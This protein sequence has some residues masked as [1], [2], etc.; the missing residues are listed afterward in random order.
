MRQPQAAL[1]YPLP[2]PDLRALKAVGRAVGA[3]WAATAAL[4]VFLIIGLA[5]LDDYGVVVDESTQRFLAMQ[6]LAHLRGDAVSFA[7]GNAFY[8]VA[9]E[10]PLLLTENAL[11]IERL[12]GIHLSRHLLT[13]LF[14][15]AGGL[16]AYILAYRLFA[17]RAIAVFAMLL[18]VLHPRLYA[19][20]FFN[21]KDVPFMAMFMISL[22]ATHHAFKKN[23][24][25][26]F[27]LAGTVIGALVNLRILGVVL[28][29]AILAMQGLDFLFGQGRAERK[30]ALLTAAAFALSSAVTT[31][32]LLPILWSDVVGRAAA[33]WSTSSGHPYLPYEIFRG[34][35]YRSNEIPDEY[36]SVWFA[37]TAP[38]FALALGLA[39]AGIVL[40]KG[41]RAPLSALR[42]GMP[43][44]GLLLVGCCAAPASAV[45]LLDVNMYNGWRQMYF[46]WAPFSLL[47]AF[48]LAW[49]VPALASSRRR[50]AA[51]GAI[52]AG[53]TATLIA[54]ALIH[55]NQQVFFNFFV[56]RTTPEYLRTQYM[57]DYWGHPTREAWE[58]LLDA[59]PSSLAEA[60]PTTG[61]ARELLQANR[62][63]LPQALKE[64]T[65]MS[66]TESAS[67]LAYFDMPRSIALRA[68][69]TLPVTHRL[70]VYD[71]TIW[72]LVEKPNVIE[73]YREIAHSDPSDQ[74]VFHVSVEGG[75]LNYSLVRFGYQIHVRNGSVIYAKEPC[76]EEEQL[77]TGF[78]LKLVPRNIND[79]PE[80]RRSGGGE[81]LF[82]YFSGYGAVDGDKCVM[83]IPLPEYPI[84][85]F[86]LRQDIPGVGPIW[87]AEVNPRTSKSAREGAAGE[88]LDA[89]F[90]IQLTDDALVYAKEPCEQADTEP[91]FLL[92][93]I[94]ERV[95]DLPPERRPHGFDNLDFGFAPSGSFLNGGCAASAALPDY[96]IT[97]VAAAQFTGEKTLWVAR[98]EFTDLRAP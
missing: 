6:N 40:A 64:R 91:R 58:R 18:F 70:R 61:F 34:V 39:G 85:G 81:W 32:A 31:Y 12:R 35:V 67:A 29:A 24:L 52:G 83:F 16:A 17:N 38:P 59:R 22:L 90:D 86:S 36:L 33:W 80:H 2:L 7:A 78:S 84:D 63:I 97:G 60:N 47:G 98:F 4:A 69:E 71:N 54:M 28:I 89:L 11:G 49:L 92:H 21:S 87:F 13:H 41:L 95:D 68:T 77:R 27:A 55:P 66:A 65:S 15:L 9:F 44:F 25:P 20:S 50:M 26:S 94:P 48:A 14:F 57:M 46:L 43:R 51:Y 37:I 93:V 82:F 30:R 1:P 73:A 79:L 8:G 88:E 3:H 42:S 53:L 74:S 62:S 23:D 19:H 10:M 72:G 56:D 76:V 75:A 96:P 45:A 5:V